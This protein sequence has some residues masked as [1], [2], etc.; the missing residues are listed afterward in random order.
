M[1]TPWVK[2]SYPLGALATIRELSGATPAK[3]K[4]SAHAHPA[5]NIQYDFAMKQIAKK[6]TATIVEYVTKRKRET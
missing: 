5:R 1:V 4:S 2:A 3:I 6:G